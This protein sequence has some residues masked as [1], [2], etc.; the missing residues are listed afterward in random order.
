MKQYII[1]WWKSRW[2]WYPEEY[3]PYKCECWREECDWWKID[4][5]HHINSS[6]RWKRKDDPEWLIWLSR[7]CHNWIHA[8]NNYDNREYLLNRVKKILWL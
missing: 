5:I 3:N 1:N 4:D 7:Y 2:Y 8:N 6:F